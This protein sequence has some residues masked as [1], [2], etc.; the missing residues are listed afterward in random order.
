[1]LVKTNVEEINYLPAGTQ[2]GQI[3][4]GTCLRAAI[5]MNPGSYPS[6]PLTPP[7]FEYSHAMVVP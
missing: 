4:V 1:M 2:Q 5:H 7:I 6:T 3:L